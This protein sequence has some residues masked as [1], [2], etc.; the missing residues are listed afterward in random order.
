MRDAIRGEPA[1]FTAEVAEA[2]AEDPQ[3]AGWSE[4]DLLMPARLCVDQLLGAASLFLEAPATDRE[5][6]ER[7][8]R[9]V[10]RQLRLIGVGRLHWLDEPAGGTTAPH[11]PAGGTPAP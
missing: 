2:P 3:S 10:P 6:R 4:E 11:G 5:R 8:T 9:L 7:V 1:R